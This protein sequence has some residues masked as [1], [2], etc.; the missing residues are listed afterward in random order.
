MIESM[1]TKED[2]ERPWLLK[3]IDFGTAMKYTPGRKLKQTF[4]TSYYIAP[5]VLDGNYDQQCDIWSLGVMVYIMLC[6][7]PP[8]IGEDDLE[9]ARQVRKVDV[10]FQSKEWKKKSRDCVDFT[11]R[12]L[13]RDPDKRFTAAEA[14]N[15]TWLEKMR[16]QREQKGFSN[17]S[18]GKA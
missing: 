7:R 14:L 15:H 13:L 1:P 5:E 10:D 11:R 16:I 2:P 3:L 9:I 18:A 12:L 4:G 6:G 8:F 17:A